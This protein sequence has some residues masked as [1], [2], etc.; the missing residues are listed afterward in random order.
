MPLLSSHCSAAPCQ[1]RSGW[2]TYFESDEVEL[3]ATVQA[4]AAWACDLLLPLHQA[5]CTDGACCKPRGARAHV[6][7]LHD[8]P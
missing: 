4:A 7:W 2:L 1:R 3:P 5:E 6:R 8:A